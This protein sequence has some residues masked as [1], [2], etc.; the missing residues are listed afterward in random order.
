VLIAAGIVGATVMPHVV[1]PHSALTKN[2]I[3][4]RD[5]SERHSLLRFQ[6]LDV[7]IALSLAGLINLAMMFLAAS[8][9][10][11]RGIPLV[12]SLA[13]AHAQLLLAYRTF[14]G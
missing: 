5:N 6:R 14:A 13:G 10:H 11:H 8:L 3:P 2:R 1:Y 7:L 12:D 9:F 4:C